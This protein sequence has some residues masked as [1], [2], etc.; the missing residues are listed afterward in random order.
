MDAHATE[1]MF[2]KQRVTLPH[3]YAQQQ[4]QADDTSAKQKVA[5]SPQDTDGVGNVML[6]G[7]TLLLDFPYAAYPKNIAH[8]V[9]MPYS[10]AI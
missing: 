2:A 3:G 10:L 5:A 4:G 7:V 8:W 9:R 1:Q 6:E